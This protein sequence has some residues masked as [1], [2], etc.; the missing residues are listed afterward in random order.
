MKGSKRKSNSID[1]GSYISHLN[2]D[3][4]HPKNKKALHL[5]SEFDEF[6][7]TVDFK[8]ST[9]KEAENQEKALENKRLIKSAIESKMNNVN[10]TKIDG[11]L[12]QISNIF[13]ND[14]YKT[15]FSSNINYFILFFF[16]Y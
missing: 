14:F 6:Y 4:E 12:S 10:K 11:A 9:N 5:I 2:E 3:K 8:K 15:N 7:K 13:N 1:M 16:K